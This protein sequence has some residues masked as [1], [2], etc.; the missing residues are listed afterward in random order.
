MFGID[1]FL[2]D[3]ET[4]GAFRVQIA[5]P[6]HIAVELGAT[7]PPFVMNCYDKGT[8]RVAA[9]THTHSPPH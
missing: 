5:S 4:H 3:A 9:L 2:D 1:T 6:E 7:Q 8:A